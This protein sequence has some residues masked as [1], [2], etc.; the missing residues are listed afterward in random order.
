MKPLYFD[1]NAT[2]PVLPRVLRAMLPFFTDQ[3][4]NPGSPHLWGLKAKKAV[5]EARAKLAGLIGASPEEIHFTS[6][7]TESNC[8]ALHGVFAS[9]PGGSLVTSVIE[10][11]AI[12]ETAKILREKGLAVDILPCSSEGL[13]E[14][15]PET[16]KSLAGVDLVSV[17]LANNETGAIQPVAE[18]AERAKK[19]GALMHTDASQ[20]VGKIAVDVNELGVDMLTIAGHKMYAPKGVGA[21]YVRK[22]VEL[23][24]LL[25]GGGQEGGLRAGTENVAYMAALG[26]AALLASEDL[27]VEEARQRGLGKQLL[28]GLKELGVDF[29]LHAADALRLPGTM[30]IGFKGIEAGSL[31]SGLVGREVGL[32]AG[33]ACHGGETAVSHVL[34]AMGVPA[35]YAHGTLRIS[36]GRPTSREDMAE[37]IRRLGQSLKPLL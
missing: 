14:T 21:L 6:C 4:G 36:W 34:A 10:H 22:G 24:P 20:A 3:F 27:A 25:T 28:A 15:G 31:L 8:L 23:T 30:S 12:L 19:A 33:A 2:S 7:A 5:D 16:E 32:S 17:M 18:L 26:E 9:R 13:I 29:R 37:L 1:Y 11:P 35:E